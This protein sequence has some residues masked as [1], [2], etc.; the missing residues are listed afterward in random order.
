MAA[1]RLKWTLIARVKATG[2]VSTT[3]EQGARRVRQ[4][5]RRPLAHHPFHELA[6]AL[7]AGAR[8]AGSCSD[9]TFQT[10]AL[11]Q[12]FWHRHCERLRSNPWRGK[13]KAG[14]LRRKCSSQ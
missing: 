3:E 1:V 6:A 10:A 5:Q 14:L 7:K 12:A 9:F 8:A 13:R 11:P 4:G 2:T